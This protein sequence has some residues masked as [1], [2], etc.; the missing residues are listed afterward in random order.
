VE[1]CRVEPRTRPCPTRT[2][3]FEVVRLNGRHSGAQTIL[4]NYLF[5]YYRCPEHYAQIVSKAALSE[6]KG[7]FRFGGD[8]LCYGRYSGR[9]MP[10]SCAGTLHD[11]LSDTTTEDGT[12][13]LPFD[14]TEVLDNLRCELYVGGWREGFTKSALARLYYLIRPFLPFGMRSYLKKLH[15]QGW[16]ELPFPRWPVDCSV[17]SLVEQLL[18]LSVR[19]NRGRP[20]PFIWFWPEGAPSCAIMTHD[21]ETQ[22]GQEFCP[23]LM[24]IDESFGIKASFQVV[25]EERYG[26]SAR[27]LASV[28]ERGF[29]VVVHDLNHDGHLYRDREQFLQRAARINSYGEQYGAEGFRAA[30]LYRKQLWFDALKFSYDMSVPNVA[31]LD[32]QHGGCCTVMPFFI[33]NILELPVTTTQDYMLFYILKDYSIGLWKRQIE[34]I[35]KRDGLIS[36]IVHPDYVMKARERVIYEELLAYLAGLR[37]KKGVWITTPGEVNRWWRQRA[38]MRLVE[39]GEDLRIEGPGSERAC[40]AYASEQDGRLFFTFQPAGRE[41]VNSQRSIPRDG[42]GLHRGDAASTESEV[43]LPATNRA[44]HP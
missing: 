6:G 9:R 37:E 20:I 13:S 22:S 33:G 34:L 1:W 31:H 3:E 18:L 35:M 11:A 38:E 2:P 44:P 7:Y 30:V 16:D 32:P 43:V 40:I 14:L 36:F 10:D 19:S 25:P 8:A 29:E 15:L 5:D 24:D 4:S 21:V 39:E 23:S 42:Q 28:R 27:F 17:D 26:V 41:R 12:T